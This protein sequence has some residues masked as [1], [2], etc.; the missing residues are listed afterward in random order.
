M[1][2]DDKIFDRLL[3]RAE[4]AGA[5][6][7]VT[8]LFDSSPAGFTELSAEAKTRMSDTDLQNIEGLQATGF[9]D[10]VPSS[11]R[12]DA[13]ALAF[14]LLRQMSAMDINAR[15]AHYALTQPLFRE[16][17]ALF[18]H[19][20]RSG[21]RPLELISRA[22]VQPEKDYCRHV[23]VG[24]GFAVVDS[25]LPVPTL[26]ILL[27]ARCQKLFLRLDPRTFHHARPPQMVN[28]EVIRPIDPRWWDGCRIYNG[29]ST[30]LVVELQPPARPADDFARF[31]EYQAK[32][33]RRIEMIVRRG[34]GNYMSLMAEELEEVTDGLWGRC[35]HT[36]FDAA[37][38]TSTAGV[39]AN[40]MD[41]AMNW[42]SGTRAKVRL[43]SRL[44][45]GGKVDAE[46]RTHLARIDGARFNLL[47]ECAST[48]FRSS[49]L[50]QEWMAAQT[51]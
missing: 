34:K 44:D 38:G 36:D 4:I 41:L 51:K 18:E 40:H 21:D 19:V 8:E 39:T 13:M 33:L 17:P 11:L 6:A 5:E 26:E 50:T 42:Y 12:P 3:T 1:T 25:F 15:F 48:F 49:I 43:G 31:W 29:K 23:R 35:V 2:T 22:G 14:V 10:K 47:F 45:L 28:E 9:F 46:Q 30:G 16:A 37:V 27:A 7:A 20:R 24:T 32:G